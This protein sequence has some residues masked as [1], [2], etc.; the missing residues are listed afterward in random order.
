MNNYFGDT[1]CKRGYSPNRKYKG[2]KGQKQCVKDKKKELSLK[3]LQKLARKNDVS[4]YKRRR[5]DMGFTKQKLS[6]KALKYRL[7]KLRVPY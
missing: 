6:E 3:E 4:I 5:D 7:T 2:R 1:V